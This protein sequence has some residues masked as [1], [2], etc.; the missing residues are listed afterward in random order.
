[1]LATDRA[2]YAEMP[3]D[4][5]KGITGISGLHD[6]EPVLLSHVNEP[7]Q[8][9]EASAERN[10]PV[11][12]PLPTSPPAALLAHGGLESDEYSRQ[13]LA[14]AEALRKAGDEPVSMGIEGHH[15]FS[16]LNAFANPD[17]RFGRAVLEQIGLALPRSANCQTNAPSTSSTSTSIKA[18]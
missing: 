1:M 3:A 16:V 11:R 13:A 10:S 2:A 5:L 14:Y 4:T 9:T 17:H 6:L 7:L 12:Q 8:L 15:H 18:R